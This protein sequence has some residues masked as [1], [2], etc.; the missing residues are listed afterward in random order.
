MA[1]DLVFP[2]G[3]SNADVEAQVAAPMEELL[4]SP[5]EEFAEMVLPGLPFV[6]IAAT[7]GRKV[8]MGRQAFQEAVNRSLERATKTGAAIGVGAVAVLAGAG[9]V[10]LPAT[11]LTRMGIDR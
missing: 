3:S 10:S 8:L 7:E 9:V 5:L 6:L 2:S 11:F 1:D 4:D